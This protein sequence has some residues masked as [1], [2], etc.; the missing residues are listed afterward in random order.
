MKQSPPKPTPSKT[1]IHKRL[2]PAYEKKEYDGS[3]DVF[4][5][6]EGPA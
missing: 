3:N 4:D 6:R 1:H 2:K 5:E